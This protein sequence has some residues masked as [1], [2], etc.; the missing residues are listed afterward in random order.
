MG[1]KRDRVWG[2]IEEEIEERNTDRG[3]EGEWREW[4]EI[5]EKITE[6]GKGTGERRE[7]GMCVCVC[8]CVCV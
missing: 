6:R 1:E 2:E 3:R 4:G 7:S 5:E 8:V